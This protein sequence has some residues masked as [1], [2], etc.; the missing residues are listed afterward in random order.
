MIIKPADFL[1][2]IAVVDVDEMHTALLS[3]VLLT[4]VCC[5]QELSPVGELKAAD[6]TDYN[7]SKISQLVLENMIYAE[8]IAA[9]NCHVIAQ[10]M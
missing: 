5:S 9:P 7:F 8:L 10:R 1:E 2:S 6:P 4:G 3:T